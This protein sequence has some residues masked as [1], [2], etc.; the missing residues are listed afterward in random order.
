MCAQV[1]EVQQKFFRLVCDPAL[2]PR[3]NLS[4]EVNDG[5]KYVTDRNCQPLWL[6]GLCLIRMI[7]SF[8]GVRPANNQT[9]NTTKLK[10]VLET[11]PTLWWTISFSSNI[12]R[13]KMGKL[14]FGAVTVY[15][16]VV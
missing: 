3:L 12:T 1:P 5:R 6:S 11:E 14:W 2:L 15:E 8:V 4:N 9:W 13:I 10:K 16:L 7:H